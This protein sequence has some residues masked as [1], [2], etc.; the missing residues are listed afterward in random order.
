MLHLHFFKTTFVIVYTQIWHFSRLT[1]L[2]ILKQYFFFSIMT[3]ISFENTQHFLAW[4]FPDRLCQNLAFSRFTLHFYTE[5]ILLFQYYG[6]IF[7]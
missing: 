3:I 2:F 5:T 6:H 1:I 7:I 4:T